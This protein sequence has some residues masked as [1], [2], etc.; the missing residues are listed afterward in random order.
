[1]DISP[2]R[3]AKGIDMEYKGS[4]FGYVAKVMKERNASI[5]SST[6]HMIIWS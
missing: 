4:L 3:L 6:M 5:M 2:K 1:M